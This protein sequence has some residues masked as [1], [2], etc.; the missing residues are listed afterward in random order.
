[1]KKRLRKKLRL[2]EFREFGFEVQFRL[3]ADLAEDAMWAF[4][5]AFLQQAIEGNSLMCGGSCGRNWDVFVTR[6]GRGS[7]SEQQRAAVSAWLQQ[8]PLVSE[9]R[10][11]PPIDAWHSA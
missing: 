5:D 3:P 4:S 9:I 10:V 8:H 6:A 11:G 7:A 1:M 2:G